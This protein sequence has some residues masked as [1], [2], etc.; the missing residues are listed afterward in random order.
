MRAD[1]TGAD[2]DQDHARRL[3]GIAVYRLAQ[4]ARDQQ[5]GRRGQRDEV[6][7]AEPDVDAVLGGPG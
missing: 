6:A 7:E 1:A 5:A 4:V 3:L 2:L